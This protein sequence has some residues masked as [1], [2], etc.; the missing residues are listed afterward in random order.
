M[1]NK[2]HQNNLTA[3]LKNPRTKR[4]SWDETFMNLALL[5]AQRTAC[6]FHTCGVV[7]VDQNKRIVSVGYNG[8]TE[9][10]YHCI[11]VG[12]AKVDGN[13]K[14]GK[15]ERC[16]GVHAEIN[17]IINAQ[18]TRRLRGA[19]MYSVTIPCYDC[20]KA[21]NNVGIKEIVYFEKYERIKTGGEEKEEES[22]ALE[23]IKKRGINLRKYNGKI[24]CIPINNI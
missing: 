14:T 24:Y 13:P 20:T 17:A 11:E 6:K 10:D 3:S 18:D 23:L 8:P 12:C 16:R 15:L 1:E 5:V 4:L 9:G 22:E 19:T 2:N 7:I 21:L